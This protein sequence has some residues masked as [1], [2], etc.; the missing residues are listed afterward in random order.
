MKKKKKK[1]L[2]VKNNHKWAPTIQQ[3]ENSDLKICTT[4][5]NVQ[6]A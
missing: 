5:S 3:I 1:D 6:D 2:R 4:Y